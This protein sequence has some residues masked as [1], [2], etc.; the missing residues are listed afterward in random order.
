MTLEALVWQLFEHSHVVTSGVDN[1]THKY[2]GLDLPIWRFYLFS[3][4]SFTPCRD[5]VLDV[6]CEDL[7]YNQYKSDTCTIL[8]V[9]LTVS[10]GLLVTFYIRH[11]CVQ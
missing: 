3:S 9:A 8:S 4:F 11:A 2:H 6:V 1:I 10:Q 5:Y 7:W